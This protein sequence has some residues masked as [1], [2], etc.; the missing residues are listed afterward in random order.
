[1]RAYE[2]FLEYV[3]FPTTSDPDNTK[4]TPSTKQQFALAEKLVEELRA[5]GVADARM[6]ELCYVYA[7]IPASEGF[8]DA[9][10][11]GLIAHLDTSPD[12]PGDGVMPVVHEHYDGGDVRLPRGRVIPVD[13]FPAL[14]TLRGKTLITA[15][16]DTLLGAD[17]KAGIAEIMT[18]CEA[19]LKGEM[20]HGKV[21]V[22]FTPDEEIGNGSQ[23]FDVKG[24]GADYAYT[25]DG[26]PVGE[27]E[28]E[29]F[30]AAKVTLTFT[31]VEVHP[32]QAKDIMVNAAAMAAAFDSL[33]PADERPENTEGR[34]GYYH[35][36]KSKGEVGLA[37]SE[38]LL[39]DH[40]ADSFAARKQVLRD[41]AAELERRHGEG[42]VK[43]V[44]EDEY[45][46][47]GEVIEQHYHLVVIAKESVEKAG[48]PLDLQA[49]R[50]GTDGSALSFMGLPC[51]NLGTG[52]L[53]Y[54]GPNECIAAEDMD[55]AVEVMLHILERYA[56]YRV[57]SFDTMSL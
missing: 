51:P 10:A 25:V 23:G 45:R 2:R 47:M 5:L 4:A 37:T 40:E 39:R 27:I 16:G 11:I 42:R 36:H 32:G 19:L 34:Q 3:K 48:C 53:Y 52:G 14:K 12:A 50:G 33:L 31:G 7:S 17:D 26:G 6:D 24:F 8:E 18:V 35:L 9:P 54:H 21:C 43:V 13:T 28:W 1:M 49:A 56:T 44:I 20:P 30:N 29:T 57:P 55:K 15:S 22:A 46:N 38:Y 41:A